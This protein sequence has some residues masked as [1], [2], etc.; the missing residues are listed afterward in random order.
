MSTDLFGEIKWL[1]DLWLLLVQWRLYLVKCKLCDNLIGLELKL[2]ECIKDGQSMLR[3]ITLNPPLSGISAVVNLKFSSIVV[4]VV[5]NWKGLSGSMAWFDS[6]NILSALNWP[7]ELV[8]VSSS[9]PLNYFGFRIFFFTSN[10]NSLSSQ[11]TNEEISI[12]MF[13]PSPS[14]IESFVLLPLN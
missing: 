7:P 8:G 14:L 2:I 4:W 12:S 5:M 6:P 11:D 13:F 1:I 10:V 9:V 3:D